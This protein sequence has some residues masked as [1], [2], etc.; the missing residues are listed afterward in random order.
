VRPRGATGCTVILDGISAVLQGTLRRRWRAVGG[1]GGVLGGYSQVL[2]SIARVLACAAAAAWPRATRGELSC[3]GVYVSGAAGSNAC[4]AGSVRIETE[5]ACRAA[6]TAA[7]MTPHPSFVETFY[8]ASRGCIYR[9]SDNAAWFNAHAVGAGR[10]DTQLLCAAV[11]AGAPIDVLNRYS[12]GTRMN[13]THMMGTRRVLTV[14]TLRVLE[15]Y[16][17]QRRRCFG[18]GRRHACWLV[19]ASRCGTVVLTGTKGYYGD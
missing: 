11:T 12:T 15:G 6:A 18:L 8:Y 9:T 14:S 5:A 16:S 17:T 2:R 19:W 1:G 10:S 4:P 13:G 3:A 7:G